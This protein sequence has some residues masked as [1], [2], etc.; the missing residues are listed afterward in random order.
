MD[1]CEYLFV[2]KQEGSFNRDFQSTPGS[3]AY[4]LPCHL[5]AQNIG[6]RSRDMMKLIPGATIKLIDQCSAHDGTWAMKKESFRCRCWQGRK[7]S[8]A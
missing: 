1:L 7:H 8:M 5:K 6:Y 2:L 4:H 3:I